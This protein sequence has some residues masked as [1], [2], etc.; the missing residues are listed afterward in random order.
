MKILKTETIKD[1]IRIITSK[2]L[3]DITLDEKIELAR[4]YNATWY[5]G[6]YENKI[7]TLMFKTK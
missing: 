2:N 7:T 5:G 4:K 1:I 6:T 3:F